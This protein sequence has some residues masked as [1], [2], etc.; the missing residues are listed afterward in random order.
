ML[1]TSQ[2]GLFLCYCKSN[3]EKLKFAVEEFT[4]KAAKG[5]Q[6]ENL[7]SKVGYLWSKEARVVLVARKGDWRYR[8]MR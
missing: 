4:H 7:P 8:R 1:N 3:A 5:K 2:G 6:A